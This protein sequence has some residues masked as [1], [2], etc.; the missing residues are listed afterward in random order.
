MSEEIEIVD[1]DAPKRGFVTL[2]INTGEDNIRY[3]YGL[4]CSIKSCDPNASVTLI[5]DKDKIGNVQSY[6]QNVFD[7][8]VELPHGNSAHK[9]GFHGM[10]LW[11]I[12]HCTPYEETIYVDYDTIF[13]NVDVDTL[14]DILSNGDISIPSDAMNYRNLRIDYSKR[15]EFE[16]Q[17]RLPKLFNNLIYFHKNSILA[18]QWFKMADPV[19]QN[20]R[21]VYSHLF[22][23]K[24][25]ETF[26]KNILA[27]VVTHFLDME[28]QVSTRL[29]NLYDLHLNSHGVFLNPDEIPQNWTDSLNYWVTDAGR[30]QIEN[31]VIGGGIIH[32]SDELFLTDEVLDVFRTKVT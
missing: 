1:N 7:Y 20:W 5:V 30:V 17:Y 9:D 22:T 21:D 11:Q 27:N 32:Y 19:L 3:C 10:N 8:I 16:V 24:K 23:D 4:A 31:S 6:Y 2:G 28:I 12:Y 13:S 29:N 14:W 26:N 15:F 25:P 18:E